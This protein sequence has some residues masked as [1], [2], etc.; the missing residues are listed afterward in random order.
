MPLGNDDIPEVAIL[1]AA[2]FPTPWSEE[3]YRLVLRQGACKLFGVRLQSGRAHSGPG[4]LIA[5]IAVAVHAAAEEM[6]VYNIAVAEKYR[7]KGL[8]KRLLRLALRAAAQNGV[9]RA[10]LEV[11]ESN[12]AAVALYAS[13]G[14]QRVGVR[15]GYY[16]DTGEDAHVYACVLTRRESGFSEKQPGEGL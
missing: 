3:Q 5:Y 7:K 13:L 4:G 6:E 16:P 15:R 11:R 1:E 9:S 2:S 8:G 10:L 14:F 12:A